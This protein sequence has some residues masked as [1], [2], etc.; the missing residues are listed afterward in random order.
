MRWL[1]AAIGILLIALATL[2]FWLPAILRPTLSHYGLR[3]DNYTRVGLNRFILH[4]V[5]GQWDGTTLRAERLESF[6][7]ASW[8]W[9]RTF[10][11]TNGQPA[12][13]ISGAILTIR[14]ST[15]AP[16]T[17]DATNSLASSIDLV[18]RIASILRKELPTTL[19]TNS[20][21]VIDKTQ[22]VLPHA[23]WR[24]GNL[25]TD[26]R[27]ND[28]TNVIGVTGTFESRD[29]ASI[30]MNGY[31]SSITGRLKREGSE[32]HLKSN[33][34]WLTNRAE[35]SAQFTTNG[36]WPATMRLESRDLRIP[37]ELVRAQGYNPLGTSL[38]IEATS[39][40]FELKSSASAEPLA[41]SNNLPRVDFVLRAHGDWDSAVVD[42]FR[43]ESPWLQ[44]QLTNQIGI[45]RSGQLLGNVAQL[46]IAADLSKLPNTQWTGNASGIVSVEAR[47]QS[48][49][50]ARFDL[51]VID[52]HGFKL[53]AKTIRLQGEF[54]WPQLKIETLTVDTPDNSRLRAHGLLDVTNREIR[55]LNWELSG[56]FAQQ[57]VPGLTYDKL[58]AS[59]SA[60]GPITNISHRGKVVLE[61]LQ[62]AE[63]KPA[64]IAAEW[65]AEMLDF[66][67]AQVQIA[68]AESVLALTG[69]FNFSNPP[70][71]SATLQNLSLRRTNAILYA[72]QQ[73]CSLLFQTGSTTNSQW[74]LSLSQLDL[75]ST[76]H[77]LAVE[78]H[79]HWPSNGNFSI[80]ARNVSLLDFQDFMKA[81]LGRVTVSE[82]AATIGWTNG[83]LHS[84]INGSVTVNDPQGDAFTVN[85]RLTTGNAIS[86]EQLS[87]GTP[88]APTL[89]VHGNVPVRFVP[90][91]SEWL[92][93][94]EQKPIE[95]YVTTQSTN[96][97][98]AVALGSLGKLQ[99]AEPD[100]QIRA[101]GTPS[102]PS[103]S[104]DVTAASVD[105]QPPTNAP[106]RPRFEKLELHAELRPT[107]FQVRR[108]SVNA[109]GQPIIASGEIPMSAVAWQ[110]LWRERTPPDWTQ[111]SGRL[112]VSDAQVAALSRYMPKSLAPEG[113]LT[114]DLST[115]PGPKLAGWLL[116]TNAA[117]R[118]I[119]D[120]TPMRDIT[121]RVRLDGPRAT[122]EDLSGQ[123]GGQPVRASGY[124]NI[125]LG[126]E[127]DYEVNL[128][129]TNV[130]IAR[131]VDF[132]LRGDMQVKLK[133]ASTNPPTI[134]GN[135]TLHDGLF[136]QYA[137]DFVWSKPKQPELQ[138]PYFSVTNEPFSDWKLDLKVR[139][140][141]FLRVRTPIFSGQLSANVQLQ[142]TLGDPVMT[143]DARVESGRIV[144][145]FG[146]LNVEL[147]DAALNSADARGP[148]LRVNASGRNFNYTVRLEVRGPADGA[149][150]QFSS[151]PPLTSE[152]ILMMLT[153]GQIPKGTFT[154]STEER[155]SQIAT[156][157][158][159]DLFS[160]YAGSTGE[161]RLIISTGEN[162]SDEGKLTYSV[163]Y[164]FTDTWSI[165]GE[166]DRFNAYNAHLKWKLLSK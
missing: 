84:H 12:V 43:I 156:F 95:L 97:T 130:P 40:R 52:V 48:P 149:N 133:G 4:G 69:Q 119:G 143:G 109:D 114:V 126:G 96:Q 155:A 103:A 18:S 50:L 124:V 153:A 70:E 54:N 8:L 47:D 118:P 159:K 165:I 115:E 75:A 58:E 44:A 104:I 9:R 105:W 111:G 23:I 121:V 27:I 99:I 21:V 160:R 131:T 98:L 112:Q 82:L 24:D 107:L 113:R 35:L 20:T 67:S 163:E 65:Q 30:T 120:F 132:L 36:W 166:Y 13:I 42:E 122:L 154:Y 22:L 83:P 59:G 141:H 57:L 73:P 106:P 134:T 147:G 139:G 138:P 3:F 38:S 129:S 108:F 1:F 92:I 161:E 137:S 19:L 117:T 39:N 135:V 151:T 2:P 60:R 102:Q 87:L 148:N 157:V 46:R 80:G 37:A 85:G 136:L 94:D 72:L 15:N 162:V 88:F 34:T 6:Q 10:P 152:E 127:L 74:R 45:T 63:L 17:G 81:E 77:Q 89:A 7:P 11:Q 33:A 25:S 32:W 125:P 64:R 53:D 41:A 66:T 31:D 93:A 5:S 49:P 144:F 78:G 76:N 16:S 79:C 86:I 55:E 101:T 28:A 90:G 140:D 146:T 116:L 142:G 68:A 164:K 62:T 158:G 91:R 14:P 128:Q 29:A 51:V 150:I 110:K 71:I 56:A 145:P 26:V 123:I 61:T 100:V